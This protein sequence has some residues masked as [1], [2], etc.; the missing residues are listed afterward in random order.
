MKR[1]DSGLR[2]G[3]PRTLGTAGVRPARC[4]K[5]VAGRG[6]E[7]A[8]TGCRDHQ[9]CPPKNGLNMGRVNVKI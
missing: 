7:A 3:R 9:K 4:W 8:S 1:L 2:G 6:L 5:V